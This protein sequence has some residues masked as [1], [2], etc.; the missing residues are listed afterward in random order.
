[1]R[2]RSGSVS[3][4]STFDGLEEAFK[5]LRVGPEFSLPSLLASIPN[6]TYVSTD[7][8][9]SIVD[10]LGY[11]RIYVCP[12]PKPVFGQ[13]AF[14]LVICSHV[15][16][17]V[18]ADRPAIAELF[19]VTMPTGLAI[20]PVP[21]VWNSECTEEQQGLNPSER[22]ELSGEADHL[23]KYGRDYLDR[24]PEAGFATELFRLYDPSLVQW[25]R[26]DI[27]DP[28]VVVAKA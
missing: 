2:L 7:L 25:Y 4:G 12:S 6:V 1:M 8:I 26:I 14:D 11:G 9:A 5:S 27:D 17:H 13:N 28:L 21:I 16:Q 24:L 15:L 23:R 18:K 19:R 10:F 20:I 22:A 3:S